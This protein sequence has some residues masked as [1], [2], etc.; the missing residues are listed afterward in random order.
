MR[1]A[2][3]FGP[4]FILNSEIFYQQSG[5]AKKPYFVQYSAVAEDSPF[6]VS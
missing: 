5:D 1:L 2:I 4:F 6:S 3:L